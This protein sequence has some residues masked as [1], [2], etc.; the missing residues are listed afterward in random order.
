[1]PISSTLYYRTSDTAD[2]RSFIRPWTECILS[3][4]STEFMGLASRMLAFTDSRI[5][6][7][8]TSDVAL[9][10]DQGPAKARHLPPHN[11]SDFVH[12]CRPTKP[13][14]PFEQGPRRRSS[15]L[16]R[17]RGSWCRPA[18]FLVAKKWKRT[19]SLKFENLQAA[20]SLNR[21]FGLSFH[22]Q[23]MQESMNI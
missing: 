16:G 5:S 17:R 20:S 12:L 4:S 7:D 22:G 3:N 6:D 2:Q 9:S 14:S 11:L 18:S 13:N 15:R 1:M 8:P 19:G 21:A 23:K 10:K